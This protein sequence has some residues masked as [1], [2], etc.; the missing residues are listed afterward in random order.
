LLAA[1][2]LPLST[3]YSVGEAVGTETALDDPVREAPVFY[4]TYAAV[5]VAAVAI[6]LIPG[7]PLVPILFLT[8]ALNA[9]LLLPLLVFVFAITRD[10]EIMGE[11]ANGRGANA[12]VV[13]AIGLL[14]L[15]IA[16]LGVASVL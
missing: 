16:A 15:C 13:I 3:A 12:I 1:S 7:I 8:Q 2:I 4:G 9:I 10:R 11:Y 14:A 6:V 5:V